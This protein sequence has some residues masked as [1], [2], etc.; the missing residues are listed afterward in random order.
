MQDE[1]ARVYEQAYDAHWW[2][3]ILFI[4]FVV[5]SAFIF[6][7]LIIAVICDAVRVMDDDDV[8]DLTGYE[9]DQI[10]HHR[11]V[12]D[13]SLRRLDSSRKSSGT[14]TIQKLREMEKQLDQIVLMQNELREAIGLIANASD[15]DRPREKK[16]SD[17]KSTSFVPSTQYIDD[18]TTEKLP[19]TSLLEFSI[20]DES[21]RSLLRQLS[22]NMDGAHLTE[23]VDWTTSLSEQLSVSNI[24]VQLSGLQVPIN[25]DEDDKN[26]VK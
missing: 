2:S 15:L 6:A 25:N 8:A 23:V 18:S 14:T 10:E 16:N 26:R 24:E 22:Q 19:R 1:W 21:E 7:N 13:D 9:H 12:L 20:N 11:V 5:I 17:G 3:W 4:S